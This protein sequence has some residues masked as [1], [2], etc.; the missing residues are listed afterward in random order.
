MRFDRMAWMVMLCVG[1]A[2]AQAQG[3]NVQ[4]W[5]PIAGVSVTASRSGVEIVWPGEHGQQNRARFALRD[6]QPVVEE[7]AAQKAG[8]AWI[9]LGKN[10]QPDFQVT[11]G[12]RRISTT[13]LDILKHLKND[14]PEAEEEYKWN[15]FWD[16]PLEIPGHDS[17]LVGPGR[18]PDEV[19]RA[20][21]SY[22]ASACRVESDG[23]RVSVI[24]NGL[25][26]GIF[27]GDLE[28]TAYKGSNLLR[29]EAVAKTDAKDVAYIYKAGLKGFAIGENTKL[30]WRDD[31]QMWQQY[32]FGGDVNEQ[33]VDLEARNR[34]EILDAGA[35]SLAIFP[36]P[37]KFFFAR[38]NEVNLGYVYYRKDSDSSFS[39]GVMQPEH[40]TGYAPWG[41]SDEVWNRRVHVARSQI[42]NYALYNAPPGTLQHMPVYYYLSAEGARPTQPQVMAYTHDDAYKPVPGFKT[43]TGHFHLDFN[44]MIRDRG[45]SD[46]MPTWVPV[47]RGLGINIVYLGDFHDDSDLADPGPRRFAEQKLYFEGVRKMSDKNFLVIPAE[48]VNVY[49]GGHW[50]LMLPK[51]V[52]FSH[53][54]PRPGNQTFEENDPAYGHVY[55]LGSVEDVEN[56][57]N[58]EQGILWVAHPRTKS[59]A[60]Y[61]DQYKDRD[62]F[63]SDRFIG[64]SWE[65][66]PVDQSQQRLCEVRCFGLNDDM[67][68]WAPKPKFMLAE[69]DTYMKVPS[70]ETYPM[71]AIN[72]L[73]L[74]KVPAYNESWSPVVEGIRSGNFFGTTGEILFHKWGIEGA[75]AKSVYT[76]SIEYTF[77]LEF[78]ELVWSDGAKVD[79]KIIRL[80]DTEPFGAKTFRIP[81]DATGKKWV[82]FDVWDAAGNGAWLQP[83]TPK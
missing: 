83:M 47:F 26:L 40:G 11:T 80:T 31:A 59:S 23:D 66:L 25:A 72:Y 57:I 6:G 21:V 45:T 43:V 50:Y 18:T 4:D 36:P 69:G 17:H 71:L 7:L 9:V 38:E 34:L 78:A 68:N 77:P 58:R 56:F 35:G 74:D 20:T 19:K 79:R 73:K 76:A 5:R 10:L 30:E 39:L 37:H 14:T 60:M 12:R 22:N 52:Y 2:V 8:G 82:R 33:P 42:Y 41:V 16:A 70:D 44:E 62:F 55:H 29:Q 81:F 51:P 67:S 3:C 32:A 75:G 54:T 48:E 27:S 46:F 64:G 24:F 28:F 63:L 1:A 61:P 15:V 49:L 65:S 53:A 13:E